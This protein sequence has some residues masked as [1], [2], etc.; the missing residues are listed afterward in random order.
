MSLKFNTDKTEYIQFGSQKTIGKNWKGTTYG[1]QLH[2]PDEQCS[3]VLRQI[4]GPITNLPQPHQ[5]EDKSSN[6]KHHM[7]KVN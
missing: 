3:Q 5:S 1:W 6:G 4:P 2:H 7:N